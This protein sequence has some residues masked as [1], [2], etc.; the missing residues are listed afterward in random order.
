MARTHDEE[1]RR[2]PG[3]GDPSREQR[4]KGNRKAGFLERCAEGKCLRKR[5]ETAGH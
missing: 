4:Q 1:I 3:S 2:N 5:G